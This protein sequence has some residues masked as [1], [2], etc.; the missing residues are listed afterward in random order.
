MG[1]FFFS[2][3]SSVDPETLYTKQDII[4]KGSFGKVYKGIDKKTGK[5]IA[6]KIIDLE[7]AEDEIEVFNKKFLYCPNAKVHMLPDIMV[8]T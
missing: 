3:M 7:D 2:E 4:G 5:P 6:I 8:L 1:H